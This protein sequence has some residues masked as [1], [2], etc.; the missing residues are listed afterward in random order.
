MY[1]LSSK[2]SIE[3]FLLLYLSSTFFGFTFMEKYGI[4]PN[5]YIFF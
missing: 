1:A 3:F 4:L 5:I 2:I